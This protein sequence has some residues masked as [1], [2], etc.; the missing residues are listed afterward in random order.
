MPDNQNHCELKYRKSMIF[1]KRKRRF[2][3]KQIVEVHLGIHDDQFNQ[4]S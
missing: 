2:I 3:V 4:S 1:D